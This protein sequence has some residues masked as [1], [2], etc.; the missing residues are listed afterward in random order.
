MCN[1]VINCARRVTIPRADLV[2]R[3]GTL[4]A[5]K[6]RQ[7]DHALGLALGLTD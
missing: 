7:L 6:R 5:G 2:E 3:A 1:C 4:G